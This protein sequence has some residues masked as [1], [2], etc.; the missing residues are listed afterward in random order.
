M[1][2]AVILL[3]GGLDS[4]TTLAIAQDEGFTLYGLTFR[5]GQRHQFEIAVS[6][7]IAQVYNLADH[8]ITEINLRAFGGSAL[9]DDID[10]PKDRS[11]NTMK[12][13]IPITYVPARNT[14]FLSFTLAWA[15]VLNTSHIFLGINAMDY[16][17]YPDC[18]PE[19]EGN[20]FIT[21]HTPLISMTKG[22]IIKKGLSLGVD[23]SLT[24]SCYDPDKEGMACGRCD[25]C[26][27]RQK[28]FREAGITDPI[29]YSVLP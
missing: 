10:V 11:V 13:S 3:S 12:E 19:V 17:G 27:L 2:K 5:Y 6:Q 18:R 1:K 15:E 4:T 20:Q 26:R 28:G 25:A 21:I 9:T 8:I 14:I 16:S 29:N 24:H 7:K 23:Y 22:D